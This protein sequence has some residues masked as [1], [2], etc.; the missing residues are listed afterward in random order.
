MVKTLRI[1]SRKLLMAMLK[2]LLTERNHYGSS[3]LPLFFF[4]F[5]WNL[6]F[7]IFRKS[8]IF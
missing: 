8:Y 4:N 3:D 5:F 1:C 7:I 2:F 6:I